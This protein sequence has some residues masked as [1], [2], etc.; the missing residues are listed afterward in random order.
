[1]KRI[2]LSVFAF[3]LMAGLFAQTGDVTFTVDMSANTTF[4]PK[5]D[6]V[7]VTGDFAGWAQPGSV[8]TLMLAAN[9]DSTV[10]SLTVH[11]VANGVIQY[12]YFII[13]NGPDWNQG[14][15]GGDPNRRGVVTG[16]TNLSDI[17]A[18]QPFVVTFKVDVSSIADSIKKTKAQ[19]FITGDLGNGTFWAMPGD[20]APNEMKPT[21]DDSTSYAIDMW[22]NKGD[23]Q[24]KYFLV[25]DSTSS[26]SYGEWNGDPNRMV[27]LT[28]S[29]T[30]NSVWGEDGFVGI[31]VNNAAQPSFNIYPNPVHNVLYIDNLENANR[32]EIFNVVGQKVRVIRDIQGK[33]LTIQTGDLNNGI[34]IV[35][36]FGENGLLKS[37]KFIKK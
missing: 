6:S 35:S 25:F 5:T 2:L 3:F 10:Y 13:N 30:L 7:F 11:G 4:N 33:K 20:A 21:S 31:P 1:M 17:W 16:N 12:K 22:L 19:V 24:F 32:I 18:D 29:D 37:M 28:E 14:E 23:I 8:D 34:Y 15:W 9:S 26:W 36:A 27:T